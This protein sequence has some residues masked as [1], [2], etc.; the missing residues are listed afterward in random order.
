LEPVFFEGQEDLI[1]RAIGL[2]AP[3]FTIVEDRQAQAAITAGH[4][5]R[6]MLA[7]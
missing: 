6:I 2:L 7:E 4:Q 3:A 5:A 1:H